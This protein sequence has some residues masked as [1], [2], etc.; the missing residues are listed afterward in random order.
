MKTF[1]RKNVRFT[2]YHIH[3]QHRANDNLLSK[4]KTGFHKHV[5]IV[6][7]IKSQALNSMLF[8][9]FYEE[10][11][12]CF[13]MKYLANVSI[14]QQT[15]I[16]NRNLY[17]NSITFFRASQTTPEEINV[18]PLGTSSNWLWWCSR[19]LDNLIYRF[20]ADHP[21]TVLCIAKNRQFLASIFLSGTSH[22]LRSPEVFPCS[23]PKWPTQNVHLLNCVVDA[24]DLIVL[25]FCRNRNC[26][27]T[28]LRR[29]NNTFSQFKI[30]TGYVSSGIF[31]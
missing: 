20:V 27:K 1:G 15:R 8:K 24:L 11:C 22:F 26:S 5:K 25:W 21:I 23:S 10:I 4:F 12:R 9:P 28:G 13:W 2:L 3:R 18:D 31:N 14:F 6:N 29:L 17:V 30:L 7:F 19:H 16:V